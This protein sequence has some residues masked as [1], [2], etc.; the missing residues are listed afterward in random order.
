MYLQ[1][2]M[3]FNWLCFP[4][5]AANV[6]PIDSCSSSTPPLLFSSLHLCF[7]SEPPDPYS[8]DRSLSILSPPSPF[9]PLLASLDV[10]AQIH[11]RRF[12][13]PTVPDAPK[14]KH[15]A[16]ECFLSACACFGT[17]CGRDRRRRWTRIVYNAARRTNC[18]C[19]WSS[20]RGLEW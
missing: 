11:H 12:M 7:H 1:I 5:T 9:A 13:I 18:K 8:M 14:L 15:Q 4:Q 6:S 17:V 16:W 2:D 10:S 19:G 20:M 3:R